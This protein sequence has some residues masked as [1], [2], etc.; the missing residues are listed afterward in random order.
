MREVAERMKVPRA[1]YTA[2]PVGLS[3]GKPRDKKFQYEVLQAA[4]DL[5]EEPEGPIIREFPVSISATGSEP[6]VCSLPPRMNTELHP[7]VDEAQ[8]L[9]AAYDRAYQKNKR[10]SVGMKISAEQV[11]EALERFVRI[12][13][14]EHWDEVGFPAKSMYGTVHD[15]RSYYEELACELAEGP[16]APWATE[17]W[18]YDGSEA[19]QI[20]LKARRAMRDNNVD[21]SIWFGLAPA[22]RA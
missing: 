8:G 3:L 1:L 9:K 12:V 20:I 7:A 10:T 11:P 6:L 19:G 17:E 14:G 13:E 18:F 15:I 21:Q 5:L 2:F 4:F 16:I 22:G